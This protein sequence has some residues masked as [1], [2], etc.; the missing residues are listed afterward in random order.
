MQRKAIIT[1]GAGFIGSHLVDRLLA[2][3][4]WH[5]VVLDN[6]HPNYPR[7]IKEANLAP[8]RDDPRFRLVEGDI[9]DDLA[10]DRAFAAAG[11]PAIVVHL[12]GL[13]GVRPSMADPGGYHQVN[14]T[15]TLRVL[16]K[17]KENRCPH[18]MLA[19]SSSVYGNNPELP[20]S[21]HQKADPISPYGATKLIAEE[22]TRNFDHIMGLPSTVL[23]FFTVYGPRQ[24]PDLAIH[25][26]FD[27]ISK[28]SPIS[29]Y[30]DGTTSRDYTYV[31]DIIAGVR[32]AMDLAVEQLKADE[33]CPVYN[34]GHSEP[35]EL[36]ALI[37]AI[38]AQAGRK[39]GLEVLPEQPGDMR[40][41]YANINKARAALGFRPTTT[42]ADG[43]RQFAR[44]YEQTTLAAE[45]R[46]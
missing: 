23:R 20:W 34:L 10:L 27:H 45:V 14:V 22:F 42:L 4:G 6:F 26:F 21:E 36:R 5:V 37:A 8:H 29:R 25:K 31:A 43:L 30:G 46:K 33:C 18:F 17:A 38:E 28:G 19:S 35:V 11:G 9:L 32:A 39:A 12:A 40:R 1:G 7:H 13:V 15:G 16:V 2:E 3:G 44:W 41:T 24:R